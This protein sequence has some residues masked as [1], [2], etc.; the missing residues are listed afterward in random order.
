MDNSNRTQPRNDTPETPDP[1][2]NRA[3]RGF[4]DRVFRLAGVLVLLCSAVAG[5][6]MIDYRAFTQTQLNVPAEGVVVEIPN[7]RSVRGIA[8]DLFQRALIRHP[9]YFEWMVRHSG[10]AARLQAGEYLI[11]PGTTPETLI[12]LLISGK[13]VQHGL[14][15]V[16]GWTFRQ[17]LDAVRADA[18]LSHTLQGKSLQEIMVA[19]GH[20]DEYPEG[21]FLPDTY[22]FPRGTTDTA[23]L[24]RAY[25]ALQQTLT[26]EWNTRDADLPLKTP[27][28]ALILAS[29]VE[30][31]TGVAEERPRIA[32]V[33]VRRLQ[34]GMRLQTDP[35]VIYGLGE[36]FDGNIRRRDLLN[37]TPYNTYTRG[38]LPPTPIALPGA[39]AIH[40]VL[41]PAA[42][43]EL[44]FVARGDG[45]H[46]FSATLE[47]HNRAVREYQLKH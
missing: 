14:T 38:G 28:E 47:E 33:F 5:W 13:V 8:N 35:T 40:A 36:G 34:K 31:E 37:D 21:R 15:I 41:H 46:H 43:K 18:V 17:L 32:G 1:M 7:G 9:R 10:S 29:I 6:V 45:S 42:G 11:E 25:D 44:Y 4:A 30:K 19:L 22:H 16:E 12:E 20:P 3:P 2:P 23:F 27:Y 39:D 24:K 26:R